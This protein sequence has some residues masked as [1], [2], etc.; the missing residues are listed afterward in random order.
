[1]RKNGP[2]PVEI[3]LGSCHASVV[4]FLGWVTGKCRG[5]HYSCFSHSFQIKTMAF[6]SIGKDI[7]LFEQL[8]LFTSGEKE[9]YQVQSCLL[10]MLV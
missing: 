6:T 8:F 5:D 2:F 9:S 7:Q 10:A 1:M 3:Y 4:A